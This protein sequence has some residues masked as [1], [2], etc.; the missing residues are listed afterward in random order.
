MEKK[1]TLPV[2]QSLQ[3]GI[4]ILELFVSEDR[5]LKFSEIQELTGITKSNLHKYLNT[6]TITGLLH[7]DKDQGTYHLGSK[8]IEFGNAAIG[9]VDLIQ[10]ATPYLKKISRELQLTALLSVWTHDGPVIA[11]IWNSQPGLNIGAQIGTRL[12]V[13]S[14]AGKAY[15]AFK[16]EAAVKEWKQKGLEY[17]PFESKQQLEEELPNIKQH[18]FS[19]A[20][21]PLVKQI[22][23]FSVPVLDYKYDMIGCITIVGFTQLIPTSHENGMSTYVIEQAFELSECFGWQ[24]ES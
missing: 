5:P 13:L 21:E 20:A 16:D 18:Y 6:L 10:K 23:S 8:L 2:I 9:S 22:S 14:S 15:L 7:R 4:G 24:K 3:T 17:M 11:N 12:P 1:K 19:Y